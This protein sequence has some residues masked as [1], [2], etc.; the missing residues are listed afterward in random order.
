MALE[1]P[2]LV[3]D[4]DGVLADTEPLIWKAWRDLLAPHHIPFT[5][6]DY[7]RF[8]RG[9]T[10]EAML[11]RLPLVSSDASL[12]A[13]LEEQI[14]A[15]QAVV[16]RWCL[17][18]SPIP[19]ATVSMLH[20]LGHR[21][22]GLVTSSERAEVEPILRDAGVLSCFRAIV[23]GDDC[24]RHKPDPEPYLLMRER[25]DI[26]GGLA[27]EDSEHGQASALAAGFT[28]I[29]VDDPWLLPEIVAAAEATAR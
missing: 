8:G 17:E 19:A 9:A 29:R 4:F 5:W 20:S 14:G 13:T 28:A 3:F 21:S 11:R 15:R 10:D 25:L 27:F 2:A 23:C 7:C 24:T 16:G 1:A 12:L 26:S 6:D 22:L 18:R